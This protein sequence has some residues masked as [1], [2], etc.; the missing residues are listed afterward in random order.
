MS[1]FAASKAQRD[2]VRHMSCL[3]CR[4]QPVDPAHIIPR[5][6]G[7][8]DDPR[9][10]IPLCRRCHR[11]YDEGGLDLEPFLEPLWRSERAY[12]VLLVGAEAARRRVSNSR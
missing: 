7:G 8:D 9:C 4:S 1:G 6:L 12:A 11:S 5:S 2:K 3:V 10:V